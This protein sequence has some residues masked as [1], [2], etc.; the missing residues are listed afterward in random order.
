MYVVLKTTQPNAANDSQ[1]KP[2]WQWRR[3]DDTRSKCAGWRKCSIYTR[4]TGKSTQSACDNIFVQCL[5]GLP[6]SWCLHF[7]V[8]F[9]QRTQLQID[10]L[11][12]E[13]QKHDISLYNVKRCLLYCSTLVFDDESVPKPKSRPYANN[14]HSFKLNN[15]KQ[16]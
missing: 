9:I 12:T 16:P 1:T 7:V 4:V 15:N 2:I 10:E 13:Q 8:S 3:R 5:F 14:C 11:D 6:T